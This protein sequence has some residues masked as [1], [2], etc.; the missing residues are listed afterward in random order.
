MY[1]CPKDHSPM[2]PVRQDKQHR[3]QSCSGNLVISEKL[4]QVVKEKFHEVRSTKRLQCPSC[5]FRMKHFRFSILH[6]DVDGC[7]HCKMFWFDHGEMQDIN[8]YIKKYHKTAK[9]TVGD[10]TAVK[11]KTEEAKLYSKYMEHHGFEGKLGMDQ[12]LTQIFLGLPAEHN[13]PPFRRPYITWILIVLNVLMALA[14]IFIVSQPYFAQFML[15]VEKPSLTTIVTSMFSHGGFMHIFGNMYMLKIHG[16]NVEDLLGKRHYFILYMLSGL[17]GAFAYMAVNSQGLV[18]GASGAVAGVS[19]A[20]YYLF[21]KAKFSFRFF[22]LFKFN[23]PAWALAIF[24]LGQQF[25]MS[26]GPSRVAWEAHL[27]GFAVGLLYALVIK[28]AHLA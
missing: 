4:F 25:F 20:Y 17:M 26:L 19:A 3:C 11:F 22:V 10:K 13:L 27:G 5:K 14:A 7:P 6:L 23:V 1:T 8:D 9:R 24:W 18:L 16:D 28:K 21:P 15:D 2:E 12:V